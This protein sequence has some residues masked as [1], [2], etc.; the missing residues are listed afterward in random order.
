MP[1]AQCSMRNAEEDGS[2]A[3]ARRMIDAATRVSI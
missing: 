3:E 2:L 1:N